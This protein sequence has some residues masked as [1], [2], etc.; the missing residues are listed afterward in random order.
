MVDQVDWYRGA[1]LYHGEFW[2]REARKLWPAKG[3]VLVHGRGRLGAGRSAL[4]GGRVPVRQIFQLPT[5]PARL[6]PR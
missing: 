5:F 2:I 1:M 4:R 6:K 3:Y